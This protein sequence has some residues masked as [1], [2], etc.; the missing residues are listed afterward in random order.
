MRIHTF[1]SF[2][3]LVSFFPW[4]LTC[5]G[6]FL[7]YPFLNL[8]SLL[9]SLLLSSDFISSLS[10]ITLIS[11]CSLLLPNSG[12]LPAFDGLSSTLMGT[13]GYVTFGGCV[14]GGC[15]RSPPCWAPSLSRS[16][17]IGHSCKEH[18]LGSVGPLGT[19]PLNGWGLEI[20]PYG[21][22][23]NG[24]FVAFSTGPITGVFWV[25][26]GAITGGSGASQ[27]FFCGSPMTW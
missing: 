27:P 13:F 11:S 15:I 8:L 4:L 17:Q 21:M 23:F 26:W 10:M 24:A 20:G 2:F 9:L 25:C 3:F 18:C 19:T 12:A 5:S 7:R 6:P 16:A 14:F 1:F 22:G